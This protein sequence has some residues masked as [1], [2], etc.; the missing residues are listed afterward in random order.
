[1]SP[2]QFDESYLL[3]QLQEALKQWH[4]PDQNVSFDQILPYLTRRTKSHLSEKANNPLQLTKQLIYDLLEALKESNSEAATLL[5]ARYIDEKTGFA[6]ANSL[7]ISESGFY[8]RRREAL[9]ALAELAD[10]LET[11]IRT[12]HVTRLKSRLEPPSYHQLFGA[13][14]LRHKLV[15]LLRSQP[16]IKLFC[17]TGIGG[18]GKTSMADAIA[19]DLVDQGSFEEIVWITARQQRLAPWGEIQP[20]EKPVLTAEQFIQALDLQLRD[21]PVPPQPI[22]QLLPALKL[23]MARQSHLIILDNLETI[24][25]YRELLPILR[26][27]GQSAWCLLTSRVSLHEH[28]DV[29]TTNLAELDLASAE[30][31][32]R[33]EARRRGIEELAQAPAETID[34]I[35]RIAGGNPLA[36]KLLIGQVQVRSL[37]RVL[38]DLSEARGRQVEALYEFI[39]RQAWDLLDDNTRRVFVAMPLA[40]RP[41]TTLTHLAGVTGIEE[42]A[43]YPSLDLLIRLSLVDVGGTIHE[44]RY[45]IHRL[46]ETFLHRQV[47]KWMC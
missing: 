33:D 22:D 42:E 23:R 5:Q 38:A 35:H 2:Q 39:Y 24:A 29:H 47:L 20:T 36:L 16:D 18:I 1:M 28:G 31:L 12:T 11:D 46:T 21:Q 44:R 17:L 13:T 8:R 15:Q 27:L 10:T 6:V 14:D 32:I 25:D 37:P 43:L 3:E 19:R 4:N 45:Y 41:G 26:E 40:A 34:H 7:G 30:D 9:R